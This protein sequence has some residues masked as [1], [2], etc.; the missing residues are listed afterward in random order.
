M[1]K[2][3]NTSPHLFAKSKSDSDPMIIETVAVNF[4]PYN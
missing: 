1:E 4:S 2:E 3:L